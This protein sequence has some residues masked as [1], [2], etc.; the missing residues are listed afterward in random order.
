M[1]PSFLKLRFGC[2]DIKSVCCDGARFFAKPHGKVPN[3]GIMP[4][5]NSG[6][7]RLSLETRTK[8]CLADAFFK[9]AVAGLLI[10][11]KNPFERIAKGI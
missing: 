11:W 3:I 10:R 1:G 8:A 9:P 7:G 6:S 4:D 2:R 5:A